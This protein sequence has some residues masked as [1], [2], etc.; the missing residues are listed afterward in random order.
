MACADGPL[1]L[2]LKMFDF[3]I[4]EVTTNDVSHTASVIVYFKVATMLC[5]NLFQI[6][7]WAGLLVSDRKL[8]TGCRFAQTLTCCDGV[9][10]PL[11]MILTPSNRVDTA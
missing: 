5:H 8:A 11:T 2:A 9:V 10:K 4:C 6:L 7:G 1:P 3:G